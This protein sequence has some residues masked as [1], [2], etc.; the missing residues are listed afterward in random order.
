MCPTWQQ[1]FCE[2]KYNAT[3]KG[4]PACII[5][6][7]AALRACDIFRAL[8]EFNAKVRVAKIFAKHFKVKEQKLFL[9]DQLV[10]IAIGT[11][12]RIQKL[13]EENALRF[14]RCQFL[15]V[16]VHKDVKNFT[17]F[18]IKAMKEDFVRMYLRCC[19][20]KVSEGYMKIALF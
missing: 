7:S 13:C 9:Q 1:T 6:T 14:S 8:K 4:S 19:H 3:E 12:N 10:H 17:L 2:K 18:D 5:V 16:D 11:P 20:A 15:V